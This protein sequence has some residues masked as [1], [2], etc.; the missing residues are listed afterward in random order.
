MAA[1]FRTKDHSTNANNYIVSSKS[2]TTLV[3]GLLKPYVKWLLIIFAAMIVETIMSLASP[4]PFKI[5]I[6]NVIGDNQLPKK[7]GWMK[8]MLAIENKMVLA[9]MAAITLIILTALGEIGGYINKYYTESVAQNVANDL[10]RRMYH[11]L[12]RLSL[13][14]YDTHQV[15]KLSLIHI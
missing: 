15:G 14:Y 5:I 12:L 1:L 8:N 11:H 13:S 7:L 10:R 2:L 9:Y 4:W 6:D 3:I